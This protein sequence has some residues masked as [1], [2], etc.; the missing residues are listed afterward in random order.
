M[1]SRNTN[2]KETIMLAALTE[3]DID[4]MSRATA[5][6]DA[7]AHSA[8]NGAVAIACLLA[9]SQLAYAGAAPEPIKHPIAG[10]SAAE[11]RAALSLLSTLSVAA[12]AD[13]NV[14]EAIHA[15]QQAY[16]AT[17]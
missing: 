9:A 8:E 1:T 15:A 14:L 3:Q 10:D 7:V 6:L 12:F 17:R 2:W 16:A 5:L 11:I 4:T 13:E